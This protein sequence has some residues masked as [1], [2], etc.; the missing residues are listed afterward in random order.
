MVRCQ[1][2]R[3]FGEGV[4]VV[5]VMVVVVHVGEVDHVDSTSTRS[6]GPANIG[7]GRQTCKAGRLPACLPA[8]LHQ[9]C[10]RDLALFFCVHWAEAGF[11]GPLTQRPPQTLQAF[12]CLPT[13]NLYQCLSH[14]HTPAVRRRS[15]R[16]LS[17][18]NFHGKIIW[19]DLYPRYMDKPRP[20][21]SYTP[22]PTSTTADAADA[23]DAAQ[24]E[25]RDLQLFFFF[26]PSLL[27]PVL[28]SK[29]VG[30]K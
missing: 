20:C 16:T 28:L 22:P 14:V 23:A 18:P 10:C 5:V 12:Q 6:T 1:S 9:F 15:S 25:S 8:A 19:N 4:V 26:L 11:Q 7:P 30:Q 17:P 21:P 2:E 13:C 3:C 29:P 24:T 27:S